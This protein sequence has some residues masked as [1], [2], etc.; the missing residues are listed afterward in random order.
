MLSPEQ[1]QEAAEVLSATT[2][3]RAAL[4]E[5]AQNRAF[6][7]VLSPSDIFDADVPELKLLPTEHADILQPGYTQTVGEA[8]GGKTTFLTWMA[9]DLCLRR[10]IQVVHLDME[11]GLAG[12]K[13]S[14]TAL[15]NPNE[16]QL[17]R[18]CGRWH[19]VAKESFHDGR[20]TKPEHLLAILDRAVPPGALVIL[21]GMS[22]YGSWAGV[23]MN[24]GGEIRRTIAMFSSWAKNN[25]SSFVNVE[26]I[27]KEA[28]K[29]GYLHAKG[30]IEST[31]AADG[32]LF[33]KVVTPFSRT[34]VGG[35]EVKTGAKRVRGGLGSTEPRYFMAGGNG[36][37]QLILSP[38]KAEDIP[39][40]ESPD[41]DAIVEYLK[42]HC[43]SKG[44]AVTKKII[45]AVTNVGEATAGAILDRMF[46]LGS[47]G[48]AKEG[49]AYKYWWLS[50]EELRDRPSF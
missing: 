30:S 14:Y 7:A 9:I 20:V 39:E 48:A 13:S 43:P 17:M 10:N 37:G 36:S 28:I 3:E 40:G 1:V 21:D 35:F 2:E 6:D 11:S 38:C 32:S 42:Q 45:C 46:G 33:V 19:T 12:L 22:E 31:N 26:H 23:D 5:I 34:E 24:E 41:K 47:V 16:Q 18:T 49:Q 4:A 8:G 25:D 44:A 15:T 50:E 29:E 27:S